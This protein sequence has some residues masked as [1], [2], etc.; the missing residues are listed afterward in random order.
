[1]SYQDA[2]SYVRFIIKTKAAFL[3]QH[4]QADRFFRKLEHNRPK[5]SIEPEYPLAIKWSEGYSDFDITALHQMLNLLRNKPNSHQYKNP[6]CWK[7]FFTNDS[8]KIL[9]SYLEKHYYIVFD[10]LE[11]VHA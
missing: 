6:K 2:L 11:E 4:N 5:V 9:K 10:I 8:F 7:A 1:M 3:K